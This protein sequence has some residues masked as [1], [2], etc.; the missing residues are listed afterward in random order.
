M[1]SRSQALRFR[2]LREHC[3][4]MTH[5][6]EADAVQEPSLKLW[7]SRNAAE[8]PMPNKLLLLSL[9][10]FFVFSCLSC[11]LDLAVTCVNC[12]ISVT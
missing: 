3:S 5:S 8:V 10:S 9:S 4:P 7:D 11:T 6:F 12:I 1:T 2:S